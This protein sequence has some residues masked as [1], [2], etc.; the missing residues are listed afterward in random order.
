MF[1]LLQSFVCLLYWE[2]L[3]TFSEHSFRNLVSSH[4]GYVG[5]DTPFDVLALKATVRSKTTTNRFM[6][7]NLCY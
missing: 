7:T 2:Y 6:A 5:L 3:T 4:K 1:R